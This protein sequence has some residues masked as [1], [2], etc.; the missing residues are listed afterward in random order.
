M[1]VWLESSPACGW[2]LVDFQH[3][4]F[5]RLGLEDQMVTLVVSIHDKDVMPILC[6]PLSP[7][8]LNWYGLSFGGEGTRSDFSLRIEICIN[9]DGSDLHNH[10]PLIKVMISCFGICKHRIVTNGFGDSQPAVPEQPLRPFFYSL[11]DPGRR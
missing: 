7:D 6:P 2:K 10:S 9:L 4:P 1:L 5:P 8:G 3:V 11:G